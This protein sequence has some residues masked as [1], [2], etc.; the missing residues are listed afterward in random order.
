MLLIYY[1]KTFIILFI[2]SYQR[3]E[4]IEYYSIPVDAT[5]EPLNCPQ[6]PEL[7]R[8]REAEARGE[9]VNDCLT[10]NIFTPNVFYLK[11]YKISYPTMK[12]CILE[13]WYLSR[14]GI[15]SW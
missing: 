5:K 11:I 3:A 14:I 10:L 15:C 8:I 1:E 2:F 12:S 9:D 7:Q 13:N 4:P 6:F